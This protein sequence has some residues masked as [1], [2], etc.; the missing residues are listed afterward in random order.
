VPDLSY[1]DRRIEAFGRDHGVPV[2]TL[3]PA[4]AEAA[5]AG[6]TFLNGFGRHV[7][8]GHWNPA[9]HRVAAR[10]VAET[11]CAEVDADRH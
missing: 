10:L 11:L 5:R 9:G 6:A 4:M 7:G 8:E 2:L 1:A 3:A